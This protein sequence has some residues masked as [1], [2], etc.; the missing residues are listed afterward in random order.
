M[1]TAVV[2]VIEVLAVSGQS[3]GLRQPIDQMLKTLS[4]I[5]GCLAYHVMRSA[6]N[7]DLWII[8]GYWESTAAMHSH[9]AHPALNDLGRLLDCHTVNR[10]A[11]GSFTSNGP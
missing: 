9:F 4:A 2:N 5:P 1:K 3:D 8:S 11:A 10:V 6:R 7:E